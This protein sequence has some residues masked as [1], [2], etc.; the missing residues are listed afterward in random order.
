MGVWLKLST[1]TLWAT[2][3]MLWAS[4]SSSALTICIEYR[5][6]SLD[7]GSP[8]RS[9]KYVMVLNNTVY[10][11]SLGLAMHT[12]LHVA[13]SLFNIF[14]PHLNILKWLGSLKTGSSVTVGSSRFASFYAYFSLFTLLWTHSYSLSSVEISSTIMIF[15]SSLSVKQ[16]CDNVFSTRNSF[17]LLP[18]VEQTRNIRICCL[19]VISVLTG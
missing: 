15:D 7:N 9:L 17:Y 6:L 13:S 16:A 8:L 10:Y 4:A 19:P 2:W 14:F 18:C 3:V 1:V 11:L 12:R 5:I